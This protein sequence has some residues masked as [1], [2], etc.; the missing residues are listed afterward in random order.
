MHKRVLVIGS[1]NTDMVVKTKNFPQPGET[2]LGGIFL[3]N[4]G[5]KGANQ[6]VAAARAGANVCFVTKVGKDIFGKQALD[7]FLKEGL[8]VSHVTE[9]GEFASGV[10]L[11]TVN[12]NAENQIVVASGANMDLKP[13]DLPDSIFDQVQFVLLQLE[14]PLETVKYIVRKCS[15]FKIKV[16]L[17]P[18]PAVPLEDDLLSGLYLITPNETETQ[19]LTGIYPEDPDSLQKAGRIFL[20]KGIKN[21]IITIGKKGVFLMNETLSQITPALEVAAIDTTAAGDVFNGALL[22]SLSEEKNWIEACEFACKAA[23]ISVTR[24][25]AQSSAP[26]RDEINQK[27]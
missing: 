10:A 1:S 26:F 11:I 5:G 15:E 25:G 27:S 19:I 3:L 17:N 7:G 9:T 22:T 8:D 16:I 24:M 14:I 2:V 13:A 6:A 23:A 12:E 4:P 18:A 21:V 20:E